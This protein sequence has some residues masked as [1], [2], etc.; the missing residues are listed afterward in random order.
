MSDFFTKVLD[1]MTDAEKFS[2]ENRMEIAHRIHQAMKQK[3]M[4][5]GDL[6][7]AT[8]LHPARIVLI[9]MGHWDCTIEELSKIEG[10]LGIRFLKGVEQ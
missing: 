2:V 9:Q 5:D 4:R 1:S 6:C 10:A 7:K 3:D 8:G